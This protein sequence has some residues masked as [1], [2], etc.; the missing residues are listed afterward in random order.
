MGECFK[1]LPCGVA[2][3]GHQTGCRLV[4]MVWG[5]STH[6]RRGCY[7]FGHVFTL[8]F[9]STLEV[10]E[11]LILI[12][13]LQSEWQPCTEWS[14]VCKALLRF[15]FFSKTR[16]S[17]KYE[18]RTLGLLYSSMTAVLNGTSVWREILIVTWNS[19]RLKILESSWICKKQNSIYVWGLNFILT[20]VSMSTKVKKND[21][22]PF[23]SWHEK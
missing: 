4:R 19:Y 5:C 6:I 23:L 1:F 10:V 21:K 2:Y 18:D 8:D 13:M 20:F 3:S 12:Q 15:H 9:D 17:W 11:L 16:K 14:L 22:L 7:C